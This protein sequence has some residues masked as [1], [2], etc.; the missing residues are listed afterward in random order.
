[1]PSLQQNFGQSLMIV[2]NAGGFFQKNLRGRF[3]EIVGRKDRTLWLTNPLTDRG[4]GL[5]PN[6]RQDRGWGPA[7]NADST[8]SRLRSGDLT[9]SRLGSGAEHWSYRIVVEL[10]HG[11]LMLQNR[12]CGPV[13]NIIADEV[14]HAQTYMV[15]RERDEERKD[16]SPSVKQKWLMSPRRTSWHAD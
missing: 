7:R 9:E 2:F 4:W 14:R 6:N 12:G 16:T 13:R 5:T 11:T 8:G 1:M 15:T 10:R 3:R